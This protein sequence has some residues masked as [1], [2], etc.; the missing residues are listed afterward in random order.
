VE[1]LA[2]TVADSFLVRGVGLLLAPGVGG[3]ARPLRIGDRLRLVRPDGSN[4]ASVVRSLHM[5]HALTVVPNPFISLPEMQPVDV[6]PGTAVWVA[7]DAAPGTSPT[8]DG[9]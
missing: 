2:F 7:P 8:A 1:R 5:L 4:V 3:L 6:P 9:G